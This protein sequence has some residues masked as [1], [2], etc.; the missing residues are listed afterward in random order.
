MLSGSAAR[1][2]GQALACPQRCPEGPQRLAGPGWRAAPS[3]SDAVGALDLGG[4]APQAARHPQT[5]PTETAEEPQ[6]LPGEQ[7]YSYVSVGEDVTFTDEQRTVLE[8]TASLFIGQDVRLVAIA[9]SEVTAADSAEAEAL[10]LSPSTAEEIVEL[11]HQLAA[12]KEDF[13][14]VGDDLA[15]GFYLGYRKLIQD[16]PEKAAATLRLLA[17]SD[18]DDDRHTA[19]MYVGNFVSI[20]PDAMSLW[21]KLLRDP[22]QDVRE[23][24]RETVDLARSERLIT[25]EQALRLARIHMQVEP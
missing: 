11:H 19:G 23:F 3:R 21:E 18:V 24:A 9:A 8:Q 25:L 20:I 16:D 6:I 7:Q 1:C 15:D 4:A 2:G 22:Q 12:V 17:N 13:Q 5:A 10:D 14:T